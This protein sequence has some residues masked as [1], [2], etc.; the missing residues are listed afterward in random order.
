LID[1]QQFENLRKLIDPKTE[2]LLKKRICFLWK[3]RLFEL[4]RYRGL[5]DG[6]A[7]LGW[8]RGTTARQGPKCRPS[9]AWRGTL[10]ATRDTAKKAWP[11]ERKARED[12]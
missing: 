2:V 11:Q 1:E 12:A 4:D 10:R 9:C 5:R 7:I 6:L 3:N 8:N